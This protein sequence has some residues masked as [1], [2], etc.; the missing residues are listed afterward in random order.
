M[1]RFRASPVREA[2]G[3][4]EARPND[5]AGQFGREE[6]WRLFAAAAHAQK[7]FALEGQERSV[8]CLLVDRLG[9]QQQ[10]L[11][12]L[13]EQGQRLLFV[14][15]IFGFERDTHLSNRDHGQRSARADSESRQ[16]KS[17]AVGVRQSAGNAHQILF[18]RERQGD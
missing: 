12:R 10:T 7:V 11:R 14:A 5:Q 1:R 15:H 2:R 17:V 8:R 16:D 9:S 13:E 6:R 18:V 4:V 3:S